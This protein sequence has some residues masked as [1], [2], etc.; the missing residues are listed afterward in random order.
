MANTILLEKEFGAKLDLVDLAF[1]VDPITGE[2]GLRLIHPDLEQKNIPVN[3]GNGLPATTQY[4]SSSSAK[5]SD[6]T[7]L[8]FGTLLPSKEIEPARTFKP[9]WSN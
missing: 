7:V 8:T 1:T 9:F 3:S 6:A 2:T 4:D 5:S